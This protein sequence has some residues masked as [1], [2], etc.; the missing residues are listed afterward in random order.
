MA[1][2]LT[3]PAFANGAVIPTRFTCD[4]QDLSPQLDWTETPTSAKSFVLIVDDPDAPSGTFTHWVLFDIP[5]AA[6]SLAAGRKPGDVG[7]A[8]R[9]DFSRIGYGG[10]CPPRGHGPH[11]YHFALSAL[12]IDNLGLSAGVSRHEV[13]AKMRGH[14]VG[15]ARLMGKYERK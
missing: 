14:V 8:A 4:G 13:E 3:S 10:P 12:D 7:L 11:R 1:F 5:G 2:A 15:M 6:R 9:N